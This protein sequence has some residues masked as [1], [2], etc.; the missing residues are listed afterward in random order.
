[1]EN[2]PPQKRTEETVCV[3]L[4]ALYTNG[5]SV[6][7]FVQL[8]YG[9]WNIAWQ[10]NPFEKGEGITCHAE[11]VENGMLKPIFIRIR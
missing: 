11:R 4:A 6:Q 5:A 7:E 10:S 8:Y 1:M 9:E 2:D 3:D